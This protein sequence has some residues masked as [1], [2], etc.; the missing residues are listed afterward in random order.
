M[1]FSLQSEDTIVIDTDSELSAFLTDIA[2][3]ALIITNQ[4]ITIDSSS[5][6]TVSQ[7]SK[8]DDLTTGVI[9]ATIGSARVSDLLGSAS[10]S[11]ENENNA[12]TISISEEDATGL[13]VTQLNAV[14][15]L[16]SL[17]V[18]AAA[19]T[20]ISGNY[21]D[22]VDLYTSS[23]PEI[24]PPIGVSGLGDEAITITDELTVTQANIL[25]D[26]TTGV[27][28][29]TI[30]SARVSEL[31]DESTPL[32]DANENN[33]YTISISEEDAAVSASDLNA[34]NDLTSV[35]VDLANVTSITASDFD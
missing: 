3:G 29:A 34:I 23:L 17:P 22:I 6:I 4:S 16:T 15:E 20:A 26:L 1:A 11:D 21:T 10:L 25:D 24:L 12:Y 28:T 30:G 9:T 19:V 35:P 7:A 8:I 18:D 32:Q 2:S 33:A 14:N 13:T 5:P 31:L 27:I